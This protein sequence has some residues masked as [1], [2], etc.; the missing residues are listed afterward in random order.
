MT[1]NRVAETP[2][3]IHDVFKD[4]HRRFGVRGLEE[5]RADQAF[6]RADRDEVIPLLTHLQAVHG[7]GHLAFFT[8]VDRI[9][10]GVFELLYMVHNYELRHDLGIIAEIPREGDG[11]TMETIH[12][13]WPAALTYQRELREMFGI[14][15]P[16]CPRV[17]ED[18]ALEGWDDLPPMRRDFDT[19]EYSERVYYARPGRTT[20]ETRK[21]MKENLYPGEAETW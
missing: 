10:E 4:L 19:R 9:E 12:R 13:L 17:D 16:D 3:E 2:R 1:T 18:F 8:A 21:H 5:R 7:Y 15:F 6:L 20:K 11:C 14:A